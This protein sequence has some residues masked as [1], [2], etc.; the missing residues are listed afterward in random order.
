MG[1]TLLQG[2]IGFEIIRRANRRATSRKKENTHV[3]D[4]RKF[5]RLLAGSIAASRLSGRQADGASTKTVLYSAVGGD[6]TLYSMDIDE[7][8]L[9]SATR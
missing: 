8:S 6:L 5:A 3:M 9:V 2:L 1:L 7:G 4:R